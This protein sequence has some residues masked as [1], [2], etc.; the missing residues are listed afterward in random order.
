MV[1]TIQTYHARTAE[2]W[3]RTLAGGVMAP[4]FAALIAMSAI[5]GVAEA[6]QAQ[7]ATDVTAA[8]LDQN[9]NAMTLGQLALKFARSLTPPFL[10][11]REA[12]A[13]TWLTGGQVGGQAG[14]QPPLSPISGW[15]S[16]SRNATVGDLTV[17]LVQQFN[18]TPTASGGGSPTAQDY[19]N[20]LVGYT[21]SA[22]VATYN[23]L[24]SLFTSWV[25]PT[26]N[27]LGPQPSA[28]NPTRSSPGSS[29][30]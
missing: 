17:L 29:G 25:S 5:S 23:S 20:A 16:G 15:G 21:G 4:L 19:Q 1:N 6:A 2:G 30:S 8:L 13:I 12:D 28:G 11:S 10:G 14:H 24:A 26:I 27:P 7:Q 9:G 3:M 22:N 18:I